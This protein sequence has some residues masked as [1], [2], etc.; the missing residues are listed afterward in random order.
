M[1]K[2]TCSPLI[3]RMGMG[4][5]VGMG[6]FSPDCG[7]AVGG[8]A[9]VG[10]IDVGTDVSVGAGSGVMGVMVGVGGGGAEV[11]VAATSAVGVMPNAVTTAVGWPENV[12]KS[13][14]AIARWMT[15]A[16]VNILVLIMVVSS[17]SPRPIL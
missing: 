14:A 2:L 11:D 10:G 5:T 16:P 4:V 7:L 15:P 9:T 3:G 13:T 17:L 1:G 12:R 6:A 8:G